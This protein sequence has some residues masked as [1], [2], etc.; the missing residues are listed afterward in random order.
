MMNKL[1]WSFAG[2]AAAASAAA[3]SGQGASVPAA[4]PAQGE[5]TREQAQKALANCGTR[6][7]VAS[8][9]YQEDGKARRTGVT[10]CS[11]PG[12]TED[13]WISRLEK[14]A[15][16]LATQQRIPESARTKLVADI[17][18]EIARLKNAQRRSIPAADALVANVPA[19]PAPLPPKPVIPVGTYAA[20][21]LLSAPNVSVRC[22]NEG[23]PRDRGEDCDGQI[24]RE[25]IL[26]LESSENMTS[27]ALIRFIR[28]GHLREEV[29]LGALRQGEL[30]R[31]RLPRSVC[32][33][34][35]RSQLQ[36]EIVAAT[37]KPSA[38]QTEGPYDL[39]C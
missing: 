13:M 36:L 31:M 32:K 21:S 17:H 38:A 18:R 15:A 39:R 19:M 10:L 1:L 24:R 33:G 14:S 7:F 37:S 29:R 35:V 22:L 9:E 3:A 5:V 11:Q 6:R 28:K 23:G 30:V 26:A 12:D 34:V 16:S 2:L 4:A 8:A 20:P 25:T 27:P